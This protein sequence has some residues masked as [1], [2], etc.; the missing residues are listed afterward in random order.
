MR[1]EECGAGEAT[2]ARVRLASGKVLHVHLCATCQGEAMIE[3]AA[4]DAGDEEEWQANVPTV[5]GSGDR[6][7][8][9]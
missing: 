8:R 7:M 6:G 4:A 1:C 9:L 2:P 5:Q 3:N